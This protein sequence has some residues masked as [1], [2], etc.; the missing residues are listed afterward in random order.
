[1]QCI[2]RENPPFIRPPATLSP[3][4][5]GTSFV[6]L[7]YQR[8]TREYSRSAAVLIG[9]KP[10]VHRT[11]S[12]A[13]QSKADLRH[14]CEQRDPLVIGEVVHRHQ[15][16][17]L[18]RAKHLRDD[19]GQQTNTQRSANQRKNKQTLI[20][21]GRNGEERAM[22]TME[23]DG[24]ASAWVCASLPTTVHSVVHRRL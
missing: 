11:N 6:A 15:L 19:D 23:G 14:L 3:W 18:E 4:C 7:R 12:K 22:S 2:G 8:G 5:S 9:R 24:G 17:L 10:A 13:K 21:K 16:Q 20:R 1:M